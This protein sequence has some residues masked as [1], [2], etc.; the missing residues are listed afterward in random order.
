MSRLAAA[1]VLSALTA[2]TAAAQAPQRMPGSAQGARQTP[3][4]IESVWRVSGERDLEHLQSGL[5]CPVTVGPFR[6]RSTA[7][8]DGMGMHVSCRYVAPGKGTLIVAIS[9]IPAG[10]LREAVAMARKDVLT[11]DAER[12]PV[13]EGESQVAEGGLTWTVLRFRE[14]GE[15][16]V[17]TR[18]TEMDGWV[19][20]YG[21]TALADHQPVIE[22]GITA[23]TPVVRASAA[24][25]LATCARGAA[26]VRKGR[27]ETDRARLQSDAIM[28]GL[29]GGV[30]MGVAKEKA[31]KGEVVEP[32]A[33]T[34]WCADQGL[35]RDGH[36][37][38]LWRAVRPDG[39][40][41]AIDRLTLATRE[42]PPTFV[43]AV[44]GLTQ[45]LGKGEGE[46]RWTASITD[47][48]Q[49]KIF[50]A[51][52]GRPRVDDLAALFIDILKGKVEPVGGYS[53]SGDGNITII[54]PGK[55]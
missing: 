14:D 13:F 10:G 49:V 11:L 37:M 16:R 52:K 4:V 38:I 3:D 7:V 43:V 23:M 39:S 8:H 40:D 34:I 26:V 28:S 35:E 20:E 45:L 5:A 42:D 1:L 47:D 30:A 31:A 17:E 15:L 41:A 50:G 6:R 51:F 27:R 46:P 44:D 53:A 21:A 25:R 48:G 36:K 24:P 33:P 32:A 2:S 18:L 54:M 19:V 12:H 55:K 9:R 22:A 29:L